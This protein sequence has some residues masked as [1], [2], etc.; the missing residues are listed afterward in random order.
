M[1]CFYGGNFLKKE[2]L[3]ICEL[4]MI[5]KKNIWNVVNNIYVD[6]LMLCYFKIRVGLILKLNL[7]NNKYE[8]Y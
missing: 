3:E 7:Y 5:V 8:C 6:L 2:E 1:C 4:L